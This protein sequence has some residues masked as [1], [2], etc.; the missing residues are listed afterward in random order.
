MAFLFEGYARE[1]YPLE[2][3]TIRADMVQP[4]MP[5]GRRLS[6]NRPKHLQS[7]LPAISKY[8]VLLGITALKSHGVKVRDIHS[9][10]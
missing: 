6:P 1:G 9:A 5:L 4:A 8:T 3:G 7:E 10:P 2:V